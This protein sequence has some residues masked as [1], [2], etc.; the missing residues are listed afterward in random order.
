MALGTSST[1]LSVPFARKTLGYFTCVLGFW[2]T[3][4]VKYQNGIK[5]FSSLFGAFD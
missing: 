1:V 2:V 5:E 4:G 3:G